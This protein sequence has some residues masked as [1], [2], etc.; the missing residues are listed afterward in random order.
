M[1]PEVAVNVSQ[2]QIAN[3]PQNNR[4]FLN[5]AQLAPG[6]RLSTDPQRQNFSSAGLPA[7]QTNVF[8]DGLSLNA[9]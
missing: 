1:P 8:V 5:F 2:A 4:N 7:P 6:V 3:L 9:Y